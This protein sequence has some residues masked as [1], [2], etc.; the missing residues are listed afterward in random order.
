MGLI[1]DM[2]IIQFERGHRMVFTTDAAF[3]KEGTKEKI[4][5]DYK[6]L[7]KV[8]K[9]DRLIYIDDGTLIWKVIDIKGD[10]LIVESQNSGKLSSRKG[11]NLPNT[12]V[13]LP[14]ISDKD[15]ADL[16]FA[17][18]NKVDMVF[19]SFTRSANDVR[20]VRE[21]LG[22][23]GKYIKIICKI[24]NHQ[25]INNFDAILEEADGI[26]VARGDLGT[27]IPPEKVFIAQKMMIAKCNIAGKPVICATQM[28]HSMTNC[29]RPTRAEVADISNAVLDGA[30]CVMLSGET[31][32]G[33]FPLESVTMMDRIC[34]EAELVFSNISYFNQMRQLVPRPLPTVETVACSAVNASLE[35]NAAAIVV[36]TTTGTTA[37]LVSKYRPKCPIIAITRSEQTARGI[38]LYRA[39]FPLS[40]NKTPKVQASP[41]SPLELDPEAEKIYQAWQSDVDARLNYAME[42]AKQMG[43]TKSGDTIIAL[44]GWRGGAG[45][46][47]TLR[48]LTCS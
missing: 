7:P 6:N 27:E 31:A 20:Q 4:Y 21:I 11:V 45:T 12:D 33:L 28:L 22:E 46:T 38:H 14:F 23:A 15:R 37:R 5:I 30:D 19:A 36:L 29:P 44:Q 25:G 16:N 34:R 48:I 9:K 41:N 1:K 3:E 13:D 17:V 39:C 43:F 2:G 32:N 47:N 24:E 8:M 42:Q 18:E 10:E 26:M 35:E 40:Y